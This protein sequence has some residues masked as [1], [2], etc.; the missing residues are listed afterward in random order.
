MIFLLDNYDSFTWN[1]YDYLVQLG[2]PVIVS[3]NDAITVNELQDLSPHAIVLSPGPGRPEDAGIMMDVV[4]AFFKTTPILGICLGYQALG[5]YCGAHLVKGVPVHGKTSPLIHH[6]DPVFENVP[7]PSPVMRYHS[8]NITGIPASLSCIAE[9]DTG[10]PM[11]MRHQSLPHY[12]FQFHPESVLTSYGMQMLA[13][14]QQL[15]PV[16]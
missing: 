10:E 9:T 14:W 7:S 3:R 12:G 5:L 11:A 4:A 8:L 15:I 6:G 2:N 1:L 13:N 16:V